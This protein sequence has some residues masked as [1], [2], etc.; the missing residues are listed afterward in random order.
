MESKVTVNPQHPPF[1]VLKQAKLCKDSSKFMKE[2][3]A[4]HT[5]QTKCLG[6]SPSCTLTLLAC[7]QLFQTED[8]ACNSG[9][10]ERRGD[11][12]APPGVRGLP[13]QGASPGGIVKEK[14]R[15][16]PVRVGGRKMFCLDGSQ[17]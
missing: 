9:S 4:A 7:S 13:F 6:G 1:P 5:P 14:L 12:R 15:G 16:I 17:R 2:V 10:G 11:W 8:V 3:H